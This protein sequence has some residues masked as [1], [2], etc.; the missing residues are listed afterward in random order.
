MYGTVNEVIK[1]LMCRNPDEPI[2][3]IIWDA[4]DVKEAM[5][6]QRNEKIDDE[7][8]VQAL[9]RAISFHD[10]NHGVCWDTFVCTVDDIKQELEDKPEQ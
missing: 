4:D 9:S 3:A 6:L 1:R 7:L 5:A 2:G 8:A 10:A